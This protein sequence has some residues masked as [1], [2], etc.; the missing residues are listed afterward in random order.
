MELSHASLLKEFV[1]KQLAKYDDRLGDDAR[2]VL[3]AS[4]R[5]YQ[6]RSK[7]PRGAL[8]DTTVEALAVLADGVILDN[9]R[10][11]FFTRQEWSAAGRCS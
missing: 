8:F 3:A 5:A 1:K 9:G 10:R 7:R 11:R 6:V 2:G 4:K